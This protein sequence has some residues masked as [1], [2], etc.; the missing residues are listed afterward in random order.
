MDSSSYYPDKFKKVDETVSSVIEERD[1]LRAEVVELKRQIEILEAAVDWKNHANEAMVSNL[2]SVRADVERLEKWNDIHQKHV[3]SLQSDLA[4]AVE[5]LRESFQ[6]D[7]VLQ[8][9]WDELV[10]RARDF[11]ARLDFAQTLPATPKTAIKSSDE[12]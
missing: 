3:A 10:I 4:A 8:D 6:E 9:K 7:Y 12:Y 11:L 5:L 2:K 1:A